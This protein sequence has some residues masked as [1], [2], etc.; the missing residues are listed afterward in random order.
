MLSGPGALACLLVAR[1]LFGRVGSV[2][3]ARGVGAL[4]QELESEDA[5]GKEGGEHQE[6]FFLFL[7]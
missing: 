4:D 7:A 1:V 5:Q 6:T 3:G 2:G